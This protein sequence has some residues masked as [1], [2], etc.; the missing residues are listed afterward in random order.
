[1]KV[2]INAPSAGLGGALTYIENVLREL[3]GVASPGDR[4]FVVVPPSLLSSLKSLI[5]RE[6]VELI[7]YPSRQ[8]S[9]LRRLYFDNRTIP[10][11]AR[12]KKVDALF[13]FT[14]FGTLRSPCPQILL[15]HNATYFCPV[16]QRR[17]KEINAPLRSTRLRHW[18]SLL[19]IRTADIAVFPS[20]AM[21]QLV[22]AHVSIPHTRTVVLHHG[23]SSHSFFKNAVAKPEIAEKMEKWRSE[24]YKILLNVSHYA[25]H[26]NFETLIEALP[27][28]MASGMKIKFVCTLS[29]RLLED[30]S[31]YAKHYESLLA[32]QRELG[33]SN[34][35]AHAGH[36]EHG[37][38]HHLYEG[39]DVFIFP[40]FT[41][42]FGLP[43]VEAMSC[44]L[45]VV[46][47]DTA[48]NREICGEAAI[49][50]DT[51]DAASCASAL[52]KTLRNADMR[53][54]MKTRSLERSKDFSWTRHTASLLALCRSFCA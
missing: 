19:S 45:P 53:A 26:K 5:D 29:D 34:T 42:S 51:F 17:Y 46:A 15:I 52:E 18:I 28:V 12:E 32:R 9:G 2:L 44:G 22:N 27:S 33:I 35:V 23:F 3:P 4:F 6:R 11:I 36:F 14:G 20:E 38:I 37:Q 24:G 49:Y 21:R 31:L 1:M 40:S 10:Q 39:A 25:V 50:F 16:F 48:V 13:S 41:E 54:A 8:T 7:P 47:S 43:L 30:G